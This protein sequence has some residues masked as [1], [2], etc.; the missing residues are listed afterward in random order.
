MSGESVKHGFRQDNGNGGNAPFVEGA[1]VPTKFAISAAASTS[2]ISLVTFQA[3]D[4]AGQPVAAPVNF[5]LFL[6]DSAVGAGMTASTAS[7]TVV[8]G[9]AGVD[10][11]DI[12]AKKAKNVQTD[13]TGKY[14]LA[15]T[16]TAK[17][18]FYP[19]AILDNTGLPFV[20][21]QLTTANYG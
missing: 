5:T 6:S 8:A 14:I 3:L 17:T 2:N 11:G 7:G 1:N 18:H 15:I 19:C 13:I 12:T 4:G 21:P 10:F 16:D 20:G 9:A